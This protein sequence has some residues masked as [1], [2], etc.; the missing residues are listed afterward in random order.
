MNE[1]KPKDIH[2]RIYQFV[3]KVLL[4]IRKLSKTQEN[5]IIIS[6]LSRSA[7]SMGAND[8]EADGSHTK[9]DFISKY[10][11]V[12]KESKESVYWLRILSDLNPKLSNEGKELIQEGTEIA[13]IVSTIMYKTSQK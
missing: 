2:E 9:K 4:F 8:Q 3:L 10:T 13:K 7:T 5:L 12:R 1:N 6:Q 11:I